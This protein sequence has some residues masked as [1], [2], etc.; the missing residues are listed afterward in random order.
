MGR[1]QSNSLLP[2]ATISFV[3]G[4][5]IPLLILLIERRRWKE[6]RQ[7]GNYELQHDVAILSFCRRCPPHP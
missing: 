7:N 2:V 6:Y 4:A 1:H 3:V 5:S